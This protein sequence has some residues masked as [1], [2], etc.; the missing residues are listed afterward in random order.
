M[1][2]KH[3][4][5]SWY[6]YKYAPE[7][8]VFFLNKVRLYLPYEMQNK[9]ANL[10]VQGKEKEALDELK[11][12]LRKEEKTPNIVGKCICFFKKDSA[13]FFYSQ[14][15]LFNPNDINDELKC[16]KAWKKYI[17]ESKY[18]ITREYEVSQGEI[19]PNRIQKGNRK[20]IEVVIDTSKF[21]SIPIYRKRI[22]KY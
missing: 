17:E 14:K 12:M 5:F 16:F 19:I 13:D 8:I 4:Q 11:R 22:F 15:Y 6:G 21:M 7:S 20:K 2:R 1:A 9:I 18:I 10:I 3:E